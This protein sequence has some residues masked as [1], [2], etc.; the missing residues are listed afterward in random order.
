MPAPVVITAPDR[1]FQAGLMRYITASG[2]TPQL[3]ILQKGED[4]RIKS[5]MGFQKVAWKTGKGK[6]AWRDT[7]KRFAAGRDARGL[8][9][10]RKGFGI[11][12]RDKSALAEGVT[13]KGR[14][15]NRWQA[16]VKNEVERR[17]RGVGLLGVSLLNRRWRRTKAEKLTLVNSRWR[18]VSG[19]R[20]LDINRSRKLGEISSFDMRP[21]SYKI[22]VQTPGV[23]TVDQR[24]G[25]SRWAM[26]AVKA[27]MD[28]YLKRKHEELTNGAFKK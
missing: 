7:R 3:V 5:M 17:G 10:S 28:V 18:N 6:G 12:V 13:K 25:V 9:V 26:A 8:G 24:Y 1:L 19:G 22:T 16:A 23:T 15:L 21:D 4:L 2:K 14:R 11:K 27:D 20:H